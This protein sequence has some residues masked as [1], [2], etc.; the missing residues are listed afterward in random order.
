MGVYLH[1]DWVLGRLKKDSIL[2]RLYQKAPDTIFKRYSGED[3]YSQI[4]NQSL[5]KKQ[6]NDK[7]QKFIKSGRDLGPGM[8]N[9]YLSK[10]SSEDPIVTAGLRK[11]DNKVYPTIKAF[12]GSRSKPALYGNFNRMTNLFQNI[13]LSD[14]F[15]DLCI[16]GKP[17]KIMDV[18]AFSA[19][20]PT[21]M[22][23]L[24]PN[25]FFSAYSN[26]C[27]SRTMA[28]IYEALNSMPE[29]TSLIDK[30]MTKILKLCNHFQT[31]IPRE[32]F[33]LFFKEVFNK[34]YKI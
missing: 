2:Y 32:S 15:I 20:K 12:Y 14:L 17:V 22:P 9:K 26:I 21:P 33:F 19:E 7:L 31:P 28:C 27:I 8:K 16:E 11:I 4:K 23:L 5:S 6:F 1:S 29:K 3:F 18:S 10:T 13:S 30:N 25:K 34:A 24:S